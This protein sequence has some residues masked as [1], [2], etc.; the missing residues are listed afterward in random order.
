VPA[1]GFLDFGSM[2]GGAVPGTVLGIGY[3]LAFNQPP[4]LLTGTAAILVLVFIARGI[5]TGVRSGVAA[6]QQIDPAIEEASV[7]LG[8]NSAYTFRRITLPLIS[9]AL[10]AGMI[11]SFTRNMTQ[12]SAIIF[13]VSPRWKLLTKEILDLV[14]L[15]YLGDAIALITILVAIVLVAIGLLYFVI[16]RWVRG[17]DREVVALQAGD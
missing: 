12:I 13:L 6:L 16:G 11:F 8:A 5:P 17:R 9:S 14:E 2:L 4:L 3:V 1:Q 7:N 15:G 10:L